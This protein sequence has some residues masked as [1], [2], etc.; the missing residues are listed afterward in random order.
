[1]FDHD[2]YFVPVI[3]YDKVLDLSLAIVIHK[4]D[5]G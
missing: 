4:L 3:A 1:M 2:C 5:I